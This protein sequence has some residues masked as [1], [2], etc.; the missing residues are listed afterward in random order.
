V[1]IKG[2]LAKT[3]VPVE[4]IR[5]VYMGNVL[6][7][8]EGQAPARQA[9]L[10]AGLPSSIE[11][12]TVNKVCSSGL[13][14]VM[15]AAQNIQLGLSEAEIAGGMESM[16]RVP[17][18]IPRAGQNP[19]FGPIAMEDGLIKDGLWDVYNQF[20]MGNCAEHTAKQLNITRKQQ[21]EYAIRSFKRAQA[22]WA[23]RK[24]DDEI[25]PV[26]VPGK[27]KDTMV[28][29]DEGYLNLNEAKIPTLKPAFVKNG[30]GTVTAA[31]ASTMNDGASALVLVSSKLAST[32]GGNSR[33][34]SRI[35]S[36]ADA[37]VEP[38]DFS[39]APAKAIQLAL[40]R[41]SLRKEDVAIWEI[42]EAFAVVV[43]ATELILGLD[44]NTKI[45][46]LGGGISLGHALGSSGSRILTT[47]VHQLS[48]GQYGVAALC[49]GGGAS[50]ALIVQRVSHVA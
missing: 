24:F 43:K 2:A 45:N 49:N 14:A 6:Q 17:Y 4:Y 42:N 44:E 47:L 16:S 48:P 21:D 11:A 40:D 15:L 3:T 22:A 38:I 18:Y 13:K 23:Q 8:G 35:V 46:M 19:N 50:S 28:T 25:V 9:M 37:A 10:F 31:N 41:A 12:M 32:Y 1:A 30:P 33:V 26:S 20:H 27:G 34:L 29:E 7:G 5:D 36:Y 39:I